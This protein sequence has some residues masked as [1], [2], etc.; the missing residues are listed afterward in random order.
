MTFP[1]L[2]G[3]LN[4]LDTSQN[5]RDYARRVPA[6]HEKLRL[7]AFRVRMEICFGIPNLHSE[8]DLMVG[9]LT[10]QNHQF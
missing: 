10:F 3:I 2:T 1:T 5:V 6:K 4:E 7:D 9:S 8:V